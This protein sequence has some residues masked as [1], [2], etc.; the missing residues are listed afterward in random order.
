MLLT[1]QSQSSPLAQS[2][3]RDATGCHRWWRRGVSAKERGGRFSNSP[4]RASRG[5]P[6][7]LATFGLHCAFTRQA[8]RGGTRR[9]A[10]VAVVVVV[11]A[12]IESVPATALI[13]RQAFSGRKGDKSTAQPSR[14]AIRGH[15]G[16]AD[17]RND[18]LAVVGTVS[19]PAE[20][21]FRLRGGDEDARTRLHARGIRSSTDDSRFSISFRLRCRI[22]PLTRLGTESVSRSGG[23]LAYLPWQNAA[24]SM[25]P[26][27]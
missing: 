4:S 27:D 9:R 13:R 2:S 5:A 26:R 12:A 23:S 1:A 25:A 10:L 20:T 3:D 11:D 16:R 24:E 14:A 18:V 22:L 7:F 6:P 15:I 17:V 8:H 19:E 21:H